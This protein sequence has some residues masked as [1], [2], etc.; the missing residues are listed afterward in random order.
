MTKPNGDARKRTVTQRIIGRDNSRETTLALPEKKEGTCE[1]SHQ[2]ASPVGTNPTISDSIS[3]T[4]L[5]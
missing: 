5:L 2:G 4:R 1:A 3:I